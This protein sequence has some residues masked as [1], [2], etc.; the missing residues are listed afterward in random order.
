MLPGAM[1]KIYP[2]LYNELA[3]LIYTPWQELQEI[4]SLENRTQWSVGHLFISIN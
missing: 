1:E 2:A 4:R 3:I